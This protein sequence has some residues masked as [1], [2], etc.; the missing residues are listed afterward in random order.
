MIDKYTGYKIISPADKLDINSEAAA[1]D[2]KENRKPESTQQS[3]PQA[4]SLT[5][6]DAPVKPSR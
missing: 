2:S 4:P 1:D 6:W 3:Q 5:W